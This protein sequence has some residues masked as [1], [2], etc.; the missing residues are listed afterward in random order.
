MGFSPTVE[1]IWRDIVTGKVQVDFEFLAAK[2]LQ[3]TLTRT[4]AKDPTAE[5]LEKC[6]RGLR[7]LF[8]QNVDLPTVKRDLKKV[9][10]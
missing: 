8:F 5:K 9:L 2:I 10:G 7:D 3:S 6:A 1:P 4:Y